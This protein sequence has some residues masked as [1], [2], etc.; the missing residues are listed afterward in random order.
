[1]IPCDRL[2]IDPS[3]KAQ[4]IENYKREMSEIPCKAFDYG[5]GKCQLGTS[6][7]YAHLNPDGSRYIPKPARKMEGAS[8]SLVIGEV[9]LSDFFD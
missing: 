5:R 1:M 2:I 3:E 9:K 8:G 6:C 4:A 7:F